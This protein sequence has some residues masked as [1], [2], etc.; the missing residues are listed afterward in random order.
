MSTTAIRI[1]LAEAEA[2]AER[3]IGR[4]EDCCTR[5]AVAGSIRRG[6]PDVGDVELVAIAKIERFSGGLFDDMGEDV[7][8]LDGRVHMMLDNDEMALRLSKIGQRAFGPKYK[9]V[10]FE[11]FP[12]D[13]FVT[14]PA[15]WGLIYLIRTGPGE[16][17]HQMVTPKNQYTRDGR[18]GLM[19]LHLQVRDGWVTH[20]STGEQYPTPEERD[21]YWHWNLPFVEPGART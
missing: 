4:L 2:I 13:L 1:P 12:A 5:I 6:K 21:V 11:G 18:R 15:Q 16:Y 19:P 9:R 8:L 10:I 7:D 3:L 14:Q 20:R 17:S